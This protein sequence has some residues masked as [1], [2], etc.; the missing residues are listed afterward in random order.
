MIYTEISKAAMEI[1]DRRG[2]NLMAFFCV[3]QS[4]KMLYFAVVLIKAQS[5]TM[6][7]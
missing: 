4:D 3:Q 6:S 1:M 7:S 5:M 2:E